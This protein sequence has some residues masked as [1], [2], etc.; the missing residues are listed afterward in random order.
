MKIRKERN[1]MKLKV[2]MR[3]QRIITIIIIIT[4]INHINI[5]IEK[6]EEI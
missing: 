3:Q 1:L 4:I 6:E 2:I 5:K